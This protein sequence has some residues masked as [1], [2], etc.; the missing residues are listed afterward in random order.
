MTFN[1]KRGTLVPK[2]LA[3]EKN[4]IHKTP[5][6]S[7]C[8]PIEAEVYDGKVFESHMSVFLCP[9]TVYMYFTF[10][11]F[12]ACFMKNYHCSHDRLSVTD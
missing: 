8:V 7:V 6:H 12:K 10:K 3:K 9:S 5:I 2:R 4:M 11:S 1:K